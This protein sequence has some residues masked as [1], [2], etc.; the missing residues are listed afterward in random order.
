MCD[1]WLEIRFV[2]EETASN[3]LSSLIQLRATWQNLLK[4]RLKGTTSESD[5]HIKFS[6]RRQSYNGN[7][8][9]IKFSYYLV[10]WDYYFKSTH[11]DYLLRM[12]S[13]LLE[14]FPSSLIINLGSVFLEFM[15]SYMCFVK[16]LASFSGIPLSTI[17]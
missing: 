11:M 3:T 7:L 1:G 13:C 10:Y 14:I 5:Y 16:L 15:Y 4:L 12:M 8:F 17:S 6:T 2:D 9:I